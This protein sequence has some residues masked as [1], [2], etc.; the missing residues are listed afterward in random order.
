MKAASKRRGTQVGVPP[1]TYT[2]LIGTR[3]R[4]SSCLRR[5]STRTAWRYAG[6]RDS[7][8]GAGYETKSQ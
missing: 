8:S 7:M 5:S 1:P 6:A 4:S 3:R 2:V